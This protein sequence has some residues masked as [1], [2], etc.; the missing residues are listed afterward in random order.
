MV[1]SLQAAYRGGVRGGWR[2]SGQASIIS[3]IGP[4]GVVRVRR[5]DMTRRLP[6]VK[7]SPRNLRADVSFSIESRT[8]APS[9]TSSPVLDPNPYPA[10]RVTVT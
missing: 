1:V 4:S 6:S 7:H 9:Q 8:F 5:G 10:H 2:I 3:L